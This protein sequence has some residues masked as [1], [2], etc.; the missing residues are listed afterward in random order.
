MTM[1]IEAVMVNILKDMDITR[2]RIP[3]TTNTSREKRFRNL[4]H[5]TLLARE[6]K[7]KFEMRTV[8]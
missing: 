4:Y 5:I 7:G 8:Q 1:M 2:A 3:S 6:K